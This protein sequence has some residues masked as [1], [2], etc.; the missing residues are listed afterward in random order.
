[1]KLT[2]KRFV[3]HTDD[4]LQQGAR[5]KVIGIGGGGSNAVDHMATEIIEG[6][7]FYVA[8][9]D[10]QAL[11]RAQT[12]NKIQF[13][14]NTT[15]GLGAG[16][17]PQK[18]QAA[19]LE[20]RQK[21]LENVVDAEMVFI[22]AGLG[23]GTGTGAAPI[24][25]QAIKERNPEAL[26]VAVVTTPFS[27]EGERRMEFAR[28][29]VE[30]LKQ[31]V[32]SM[33]SISND[34]ILQGDVFLN[35]AYGAA[36]DVLLNAVRGIADV[37]VQTG[38]INVDFADVQ[39]V[40]AEA[41]ETMMGHG[42]A[43][44]EGRARIAASRALANPLLE[45]I[46]VS[47]AKGLLVNVTASSNISSN[48][49][50][51]IGNV[52]QSATSN[53]PSVITGLVFDEDV[54]DEIRVTIIAS[55]LHSATAENVTQAESDAA[56]EEADHIESASQVESNHE[57]ANGQIEPDVWTQP[58][59][60]DEDVAQ[61]AEAEADVSEPTEHQPVNDVTDDDGLEAVERADELAERGNPD[62]EREQIVEEY[63]PSVFRSRGRTSPGAYQNG[64]GYA[65][66]SE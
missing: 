60:A 57:A 40:M 53:A 4:A 62:D 38:F 36:N 33:I 15:R 22:T 54:G 16:F 65:E 58:D 26:V 41:G 27:F 51:E 47:Q 43:K 52:I 13:G 24:V 9:T 45:D 49:F 10:A 12:S 8:N 23:G 14:T 18:G 29:G 61:A 2:N 37:V 39:T 7:D 11:A 63:F 55:G 46:D 64:N 32:D 35:E 1:M 17:D 34:K 31:S 48:E 66:L 3:L 44:G 21:L 30:E 25:A 5:I 28:A 56:V 59:A 20:D 19:A 42:R 6:V 50:K